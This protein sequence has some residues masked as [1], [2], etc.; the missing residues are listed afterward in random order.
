MSTTA[1]AI[2]CA[3]EWRWRY[4]RSSIPLIEPSADIGTSPLAQHCK[5]AALSWVGPCLPSPPGLWRSALH[6]EVSDD[7]R[8]GCWLQTLRASFV[9]GVAAR[10]GRG[11]PNGPTSVRDVGPCTWFHPTSL[12][13]ARGRAEALHG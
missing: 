8:Q 7:A 10:T 1:F 3:A 11:T 5:S 12:R 6:R 9:L 13:R 4:S 2:M